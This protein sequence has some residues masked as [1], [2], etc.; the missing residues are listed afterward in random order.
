MNR[1]GTADGFTGCTPQPD[2]RVVLASG[3]FVQVA[4]RLGELRR[5]AGHRGWR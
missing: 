1:R 3:Q 5:G 4:E 2:R